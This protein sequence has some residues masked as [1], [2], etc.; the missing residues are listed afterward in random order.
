MDVVG[1]IREERNDIH[2]AL[3]GGSQS[4]TET[5]VGQILLGR[6]RLIAKANDVRHRQPLCVQYHIALLSQRGYDA[7]FH[8]AFRRR[9][10]RPGLPGRTYIETERRTERTVLQD[11]YREG[12]RGQNGRGLAA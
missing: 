5:Q 7:I 12:R 4:L 8:L 11:I 1:A 6:I 10:E 2:P 3:S 9:E